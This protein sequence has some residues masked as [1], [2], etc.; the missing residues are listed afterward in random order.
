MH[1]AEKPAGGTPRDWI[2]R[3]QKFTCA[4]VLAT[5]TMPRGVKCRCMSSM[6]SDGKESGVEQMHRT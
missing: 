5:I 3:A 4:L 6:T 1:S 2:R